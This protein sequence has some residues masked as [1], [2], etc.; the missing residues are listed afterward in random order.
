MVKGERSC[1]DN[2]GVEKSREPRQVS[3]QSVAPRL[4]IPLR[5][6]PMTFH[7]SLFTFHLSPFTVRMASASTPS[8]PYL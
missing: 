4:S 8:V 5:Y 1:V 3:A 2:T 7:F 6:P